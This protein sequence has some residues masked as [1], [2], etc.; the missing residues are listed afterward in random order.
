[1]DKIKKSYS[2]INLLIALV[3][4][5]CTG[6]MIGT[7][8]EFRNSIGTYKVNFDLSDTSFTKK[9]K[10]VYNTT[11]LQLFSNGKFRFFGY[12]LQ[13]HGRKGKWEVI[14]LDYS[15]RIRLNYKCGF[16]QTNI[17]TSDSCV[18]FLRVPEYEQNLIIGH[19]KLAF[20]KES[21]Q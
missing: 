10:S 19:R 16:E 11:K 6:C 14:G 18:L 20:E 3:L 4:F 7:S 17:C 8:E 5:I 9:E 15:K 13:N 1:M 21:T 12:P 2:Y